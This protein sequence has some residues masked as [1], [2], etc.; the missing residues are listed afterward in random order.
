MPDKLLSRQANGHCSVPLSRFQ[1]ADN[2]CSMHKENEE[3]SN[4]VGKMKTAFAEVEQIDQ[5]L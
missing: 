2:P 3:R 5:E 1:I 4:T